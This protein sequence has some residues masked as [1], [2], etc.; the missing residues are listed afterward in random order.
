M[1]A[2]VFPAAGLAPTAALPAAALPIKAQWASMQADM[3]A[4][5]PEVTVAAGLATAYAAV[6]APEAVMQLCQQ[7]QQQQ[8]G[9]Q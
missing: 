9:Q 6:E 8:L 1:R 7:K 4:R 3:A 2:A 5:L